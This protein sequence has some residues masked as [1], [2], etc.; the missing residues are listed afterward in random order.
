MSTEMSKIEI[1]FIAAFLSPQRLETLLNV[2][3]DKA[4]AISLHQR[5]LSLN[6]NL[7]KIVATIEIALRNTVYNNISRHFGV[8]NWL[9]Q[10]PIKLD[11]KN[12]DKAKIIAAMDSAKRSEY[13]KKAKPKR[14]Y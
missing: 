4:S 8:S 13:A 6:S 2:T 9:Q 14:R 11:L 5:I 3:Q 10:P 12:G 7:M 1:A